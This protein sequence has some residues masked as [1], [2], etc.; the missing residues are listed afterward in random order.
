V[1]PS[2]QEKKK[3]GGSSKTEKS[4]SRKE[5]PKK[6]LLARV[7]KVVRK[8]RRKLSEEHF[9]KELQ[10]TIAFLGEIQAKIG[11]APQPEKGGKGNKKKTGS[12][13]RKRD[14]STHDPLRGDT[15]AETE[16][17]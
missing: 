1:T 3:S 13:K 12:K 10:R 9:E 6:P 2:G 15:S 8:S 14:Q 4:L 11:E 16:E 5:K 17:G 7:Q